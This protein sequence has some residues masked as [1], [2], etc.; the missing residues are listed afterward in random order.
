[1][2]VRESFVERFG[3]A[4]AAAMEA[5]A[6]QHRN[7]VNDENLGSDP[8][9]WALCIAIGY[10]CFVEEAYREKHGFRASLE[11]LGWWIRNHGDLA[12]HDGDFDILGALMGVYEPYI[13]Q[14]EEATA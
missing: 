7:G 4:E 11:E 13:K 1:M 2:S 8:F 6:D 9:K 14:E 12:S 5:A 3:E 10:Q